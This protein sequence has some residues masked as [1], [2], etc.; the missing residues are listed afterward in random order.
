MR[1]WRVVRVWLVV[2]AIG[3]GVGICVAQETGPASAPA[4]GAATQAADGFLSEDQL[5]ELFREGRYADVLHE[6][7]R[8]RNA[9]SVLARYDEFHLQLMRAECYLQLRNGKMAAETFTQASRLTHEPGKRALMQA[10]ALLIQ[11]SM[12]LKYAAKNT[13]EEGTPWLHPNER[14]EGVKIDL[15]VLGKRT[16]ALKALYT[17]QW[18]VTTAAVEQARHAT[19]MDGYS[20]ALKDL[21]D[22]AITEEAIVGKEEATQKLRDQTAVEMNA[23]IENALVDM[24]GRVVKLQASA[25]EQ[26]V[27]QV[28]TTYVGNDGL[29]HQTTVERVRARGLTEAD[30][31]MLEGIRATSSHV[32]SSTR[33]YVEQLH[34][35]KQVFA[36]SVADAGALTK[37]VNDVLTRNTVYRD[38]PFTR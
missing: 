1:R 26:I 4:A 10:T 6:T 37:L 23:T 17:D 31:R 32:E 11:R 9:P 38:N 34:T 7:G 13:D 35:D 25:A 18:F 36:K 2:M 16:A 8:I 12:G 3:V 28:P 27:V 29:Q 19:A 5:A 30:A 24:T 22:L 20:R 14:H 15:L 21:D 33:E